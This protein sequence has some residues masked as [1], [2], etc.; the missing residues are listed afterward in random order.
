MHMNID[1]YQSATS[2]TLDFLRIDHINSAQYQF[3]APQSLFWIWF[4]FSWYISLGYVIFSQ[5]GNSSYHANDKLPNR[6]QMAFKNVTHTKTLLYHFSGVCVWKY[7]WVD[8]RRE[9]HNPADKPGPENKCWDHSKGEKR[10]FC[11]K[12]KSQAWT[13][14]VDITLFSSTA[15]ASLMN[16][17]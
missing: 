3:S 8:F 7:L 12:K 6:I 13:L 4:S 10:I 15:Q 1:L 14:I 2:S 11:L 5:C 16:F 17:L 9:D